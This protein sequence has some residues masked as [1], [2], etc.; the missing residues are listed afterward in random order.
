MDISDLNNLIQ[1]NTEIKAGKTSFLRGK[2]R[3]I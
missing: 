1:S 2:Y 3:S